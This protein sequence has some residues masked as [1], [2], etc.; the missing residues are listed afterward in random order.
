MKALLSV[1]MNVTSFVLQLWH[2]VI[3]TGLFSAAGNYLSSK[4]ETSVP[5]CDRTTHRAAGKQTK[6][7]PNKFSNIDINKKNTLN[8]KFL[9]D[10]T[11]TLKIINLSHTTEQQKMTK[12]LRI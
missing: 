4:K 7:N 3:K 5:S 6:M 8:L 10:K 2:G 12:M 11:N 9:T 1:K